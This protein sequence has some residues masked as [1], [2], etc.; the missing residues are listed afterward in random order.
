MP[1]ETTIKG[2][3]ACLKF[4]QR[5]IE[6]GAIVSKPTLECEYDRILDFEGKLYKVQVKYSDSKPSQAEGAVL[7][8]ISKAGKKHGSHESYSKE[9]IDVIVIYIPKVDKLCWIP[10]DVWN[11]KKSLQLRYSEAKNSQTKGV[12]M[13]ADYVW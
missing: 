8:Q 13:V 5:A 7:A 1:S 6:K 11:G 2:E 10:F 4:E 9:D 12:R 3:L